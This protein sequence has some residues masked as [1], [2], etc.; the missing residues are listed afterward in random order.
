[1]TKKLLSVAIAL[2]M[3]LA[4]VPMS[5]FAATE[6]TRAVNNEYQLI[7]TSPTVTKDS[8]TVGSNSGFMDIALNEN[9]HM[10][11][12]AF[13]IEFDHDYFTAQAQY[14]FTGSLYKALN[15]AE[16]GSTDVIGTGIVNP[17]EHCGESSVPLVIEQGEQG[18][19]YTAFQ[20]ACK[21]ADGHPSTGGILLG[22]N[23]MRLRYTFTALPQYDTTFE[24]KLTC[25][26]ASCVDSTTDYAP[27][28]I[29]LTNPKIIVT[30]FGTAPE[31]P[32]EYHLTYTG[33]T[34]D[35]TAAKVGDEFN[36]YLAISENSSLNSA[37][38]AIEF[39][40]EYMDTIACASEDTDPYEDERL[41]MNWINIY[42]EEEMDWPTGSAIPGFNITMNYE[43]TGSIPGTVAG[44]IY[45]RAGIN[46]NLNVMANNG[47]QFG[48]EFARYTYKWTKIP[49][50]TDAGVMQ[51]ENGYYLPVNILMNYSN[52]FVQEA[53]YWVAIPEEQITCVPGKI[54]FTPETIV[55][56]TYY[57]VTFVDGLTGETLKTETVEEGHAATAPE[58][59]AHEGYTFTGWD[60]AFDNI[61]ADTTVTAQYTV[62]TYTITYIVDGVTVHTDTY[63][64]GAEVTPYNYVPADGYT[65][66]GWDG[67]VPATMPAENLTFTG[68]TELIPPSSY[69]ITYTINGEYYTTQTYEEGA[70]VTA[71][72]Y[73][74]PEG[75]TFSGWDVPETMP[76]EN[77]TLDATLTVNKYWLTIYYVKDNGYTALQNPV[78]VQVEYGA[79]YSYASP[80]SIEWDDGTWV[81]EHPE[82]QSVIE[83]VMPAHDVEIDVTYVHAY[84]P[85]APTV[86]GVE[87]VLREREEGDTTAAIRFIFE[88]TFNDSYITYL[89]ENYGP[90]EEYYKIEKF[91]AVLNAGGRPLTIN[92]TNIYAMN[93]VEEPVSFTFVA[94][95]TNI[96]A[97][98]FDTNI[99]ATPYI[100]Y[101]GNTVS[102]TAL[103][104]NVNALLN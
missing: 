62:N 91:Y 99:T 48:G 96:P 104:A 7:L 67:T 27:E 86:A 5:V 69:T 14:S 73:T 19:W 33:E 50:A 102:G 94:T 36:W 15:S 74:V 65:F 28:N 23:L 60:V 72:E 55:E 84:E 71:P 68:T 1:M 11:A 10:V 63:A 26:I 43:A 32:G 31:D 92:G 66:S 52:L 51:D 80:A 45:N 61:T 88:V 101:D 21:A 64:Y 16:A 18:K 81:L 42:Y 12:S 85:V 39:P 75:H 17:M 93:T 29:Q 70:A 6:G 30:G 25:P 20:F 56:P 22:G 89:G 2:V 54:Y 46:C 38:M 3:V 13:L 24:M 77:I 58:A 98:R 97:A 34:V 40:T 9:S 41:M 4:L 57:T 53:P 37:D 103:T 49:A 95:L 8:P 87:A 90:T 79:T 100:V 76:G 47:L 59:P 44:Q 82:T 78:R 83:G 35:Q